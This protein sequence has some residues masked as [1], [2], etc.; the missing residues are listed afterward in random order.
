VKLPSFKR[1]IISDYADEFKGLVESL[2]YSI[3]SAIESINEAFEKNVT[4][5]ENIACTVKDIEVVVKDSTGLLSSK[6]SFKTDVSGSVIGIN[7]INATNLSDNSLPTSG[8][9]ITYTQT[10][11]S[12]DI[13]RVIGLPIGKKFSL[14]I[15]AYV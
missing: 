12:V 7:V 9:F 4:L 1:L 5:R 15:V 11:N 14:R 3:N 8:I 6:A 10:G 2:G 13:S